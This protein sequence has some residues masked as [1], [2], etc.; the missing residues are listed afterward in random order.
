MYAYAEELDAWLAAN[1]PATGANGLQSAP[2]TLDTSPPSSPALSTHELPAPSASVRG[3]P[4]RGIAL[5]ATAVAVA[6]GLAGWRAW[7]T[8]VS[9]AELT[10]ALEPTA[11]VVRDAANRQRWEHRFDG[12]RVEPPQERQRHP[13]ERLAG[14]RSG[15]I[16]ATGLHV[17]L[18]NETVSS[19][20]LMVFTLDGKLTEAFSFGDRVQFQDGA[21]GAP[22]GITDFRVAAHGD[23]PVVVA[24]HHY[25]WWPSLVTVLDGQWRRSGTFVHAGWLERTHWQAPDRLVVAGYSEPFDGGVVALLDAAALGGQ[26]PVPTGSPYFCTSCGPGRPVRYVVMARSEV[27]RASRSRF[28]RARL[29]VHADRIV[30]RTLEAASSESD[31]AEAVYEFTPELDLVRASYSD[32]YWAR[33]RALELEGVLDHPPER[34]PDRDGPRMVSVWEPR[35]GWRTV[36]PRR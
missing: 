24:A 15:F 26:T 3:L 4:R 10:A 35:A 31:V 25:A 7:R 13:V 1:H 12:Q 6:V 2:L 9:D 16:G 34:C 27:N 33:H 18:S 29:E 23:R 5:A 14:G 28:N 17:S 32:R 30:A 36:V 19:G 21:Y 22:W 8:P 20:R 11:I